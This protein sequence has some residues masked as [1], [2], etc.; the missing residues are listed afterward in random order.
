MDYRLKNDGEAQ[1]TR[2]TGT[3]LG[4]APNLDADPRNADWLRKPAPF[5]PA[6]KTLPPHR[7]FLAVYTT[8]DG[9]QFG[10][11][12]VKVTRAWATVRVIRSNRSAKP[13]EH[14]VERKISPRSL[15]APTSGELFWWAWPN[16]DD[17]D[18]DGKLQVALV[19]A[20]VDR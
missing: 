18:Y 3:P 7:G 6:E 14:N 12:V 5:D 19:S 13:P 16:R 2:M 9:Y 8:P 10:V 11:D 15:R 17:Y 4:K 1:P 20:G